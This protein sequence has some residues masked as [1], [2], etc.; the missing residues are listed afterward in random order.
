M[1][2][3][4][5]DV[6]GASVT[7]IATPAGVTLST[8]NIFPA[9]SYQCATVEEAITWMRENCPPSNTG[10]GN[11]LYPNIPAGVSYYTVGIQYNGNPNMPWSEQ[12]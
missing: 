8:T 11:P 7:I 4:S 2:W 5:S 1:G 6:A 9:L 12:L 10:G 3:N